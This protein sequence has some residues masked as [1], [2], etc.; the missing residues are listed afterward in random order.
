MID[1][2]DRWDAKCVEGEHAAYLSLREVSVG[3]WECVRRMVIYGVL[4]DLALVVLGRYW[5]CR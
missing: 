1:T 2:V 3:G 5:M 4:I